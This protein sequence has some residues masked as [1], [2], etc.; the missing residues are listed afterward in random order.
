MYKNLG[1]LYDIVKND[2]FWLMETESNSNYEKRLAAHL[3][4]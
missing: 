2:D 3:L 4:W 1:K